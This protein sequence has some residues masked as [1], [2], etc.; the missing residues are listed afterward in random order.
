MN[1]IVNE[2]HVHVE[3]AWNIFHEATTASFV[4]FRLFQATLS[5]K[6]LRVQTP[7][8]EVWG[9]QA[10]HE[11]TTTLDTF[12]SLVHSLMT[13]TEGK[14]TRNIYKFTLHVIKVYLEETSGL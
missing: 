2:Y 5:R 11:T 13:R 14:L 3:S 1:N 4:D 8:I 6:K 12:I 10:N 7:I 9:K